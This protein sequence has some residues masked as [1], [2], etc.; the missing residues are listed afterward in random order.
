HKFAAWGLSLAACGLNDYEAA[1]AYLRDG[2]AYHQARLGRLGVLLCLPVAALVTAHQG[3]HARALEWLALAFTHPI[4]A[5]GWMHKWPLL[6]RFRGDLENALGPEAY[7]A[8]WER[9]KLLD[10]DEIK[11]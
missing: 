6:K 8:A 3:H 10:V 1:S 2:F 11:L 4:C 5:S 7:A 9:G